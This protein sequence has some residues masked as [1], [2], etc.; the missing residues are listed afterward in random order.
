MN[1]SKTI[2]KPKYTNWHAK[3]PNQNNA[4]CY[5]NEMIN[6]YRITYMK[7]MSN[8]K[9]VTHPSINNHINPYV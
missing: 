4:E 2:L 1:K 5:I 6:L 7:K 9:V 8:S 3:N